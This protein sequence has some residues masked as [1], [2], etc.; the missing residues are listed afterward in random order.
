MPAPASLHRACGSRRRA[1]K[2]RPLLEGREGPWGPVTGSV[3]L[4][5]VCECCLSTEKNLCEKLHRE[6]SP[7]LPVGPAP[8]A[9]AP[10]TTIDCTTGG[11]SNAAKAL[12]QAVGSER[13]TSR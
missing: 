3:C 8:R 1:L 10:D 4:F 7:S 2:G 11:R 5:R 9:R 6:A 13:T 12:R